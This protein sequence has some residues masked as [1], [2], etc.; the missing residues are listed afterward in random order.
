MV[1]VSGVFADSFAHYDTA[2][3]ALK[4]STVG[5]SIQNN[6]AHVRT[7]QPAP[8]LS[9]SLQIQAG[10]APTIINLQCPADTTATYSGPPQYYNFAVGMAYQTGALN[11]TIFKLWRNLN[12]APSPPELLLYLV[13]NADGSLSLFTDGGTLLGSSAAGLITVGPFYYITFSADIA[14]FSES[15]FA[16]VNVINL[17]TLVGSDVISVTGFVLADTFVDEFDFGGPVG[18]DYAWVNDFYFQD[19]SDGSTVPLFP[20]IY[21]VAPNADGTALNIWDFITIGSWQP[22]GS[23]HIALVNPIP[24]DESQGIQWLATPRYAPSPPNF[25][26]EVGETYYFDVSGLPDGRPIQCIQSVFLMEWQLV[27]TGV[28][29]VGVNTLFQENATGSTSAGHSTG[30]K[31]VPGMPYLC[32]MSDNWKDPFHHLWLMTDWKAGKWQAG[33]HTVTTG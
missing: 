24:Q 4:Y 27:I 33:P 18:P 23:S 28:L 29:K 16:T 2:G 5:G 20:N 6:P 11:G 14:G 8:A 3:L 15:T 17:S 25:I 30:V 1:L 10:D 19:L 7:I 31:S 9:Q 12:I 22:V 13:L 32:I 21:A 26:N